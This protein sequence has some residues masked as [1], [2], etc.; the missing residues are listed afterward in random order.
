[1]KENPMQL[2]LT[3]QEQAVLLEAVTSAI[4]E[5]G[6]EVAHTDN[7]TMRQGLQQNK[8][9]LLAILDRLKGTA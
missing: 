5:V 6:T 3:P 7:Q 4:S 9:V 8:K 2:T 1:M